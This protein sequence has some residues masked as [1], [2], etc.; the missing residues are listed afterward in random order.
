MTAETLTTIAGADATDAN[1]AGADA[2][3]DADAGTAGSSAVRGELVRV[4]FGD[5]HRA[6]HGPWR[7]LL[8]T[9]PF[10]RRS[11]LAPDAQLRLAYGRLRTL[12]S[13]LDSAFRLAAD[14]VALANMHEWLSPVDTTL[15]TVA[16][17]HYNLFL[18]SL[19]DHDGDVRRDLSAFADLTRIGT[20]LCTELDHGN[21]ATALETTAD[22]DRAR[23]GFL[24]RT[25][26][27]G[28]QKFMPNT[29]AAGGPKSGVVAARLLV[30]GRDL[31][32][33]LFLTA[34]T[35]A[36]GPLPGVR[37]RL[38]PRRMGS[39]VD[40][41]LTSFDGVFVP[42]EALLSGAQGRLD[43]EGAFTSEVVNRRS[44]FLLSIGRV[45][46]GKLS[47]SASAVGSVRAALAVAVR[48]GS[49]RLIGGVRASERV[50]VMA[51]RSHYAPLAGALATAYAMT[52]LHR[53][54]LRAWTE[55]DRTER[56]RTGVAGRVEAERLVAVAKAWI[57][58]EARVVIT[59]CR[60]RCGAQGLLEN[61]GLAALV[62]GIEGAIT[63]EGDNIAIHAKAAA[64]MVSG[65]RP[66]RPP[67]DP[68]GRE[69]TDPVFLRELLAA[70]ECVELDRARAG[71][72]AAAPG[73][74]LGRW[75]AGASAALRAATAHAQ[76][77]AAEAVAAAADALPP[78]AAAGE[79]LHTL[80]RLF[81]LE[82]IAP[83]GGDLLN[84]GFMAGRHISELPA[85]T[86]RLAARIA[87]QAQMLTGA[88]DLPDEWL[89]D[90]PVTDAGYASAY[91]DPEG[92][93]H[94]S[95]VEARR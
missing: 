65:H 45:T 74:A 33:F 21:D 42:R 9:E 16:G 87:G 66:P 49:H 19:L 69:L 62:T 61:N 36:E 25:P 80:G 58:W 56:D 84:E 18:G 76:L 57:T 26:H 47:M 93:W 50:P 77:R 22:Y 10:R 86:D 64:G 29:S 85:E 48:H 51:H 68:A 43:A 37:V 8:T 52:L 34:L 3:A 17:I 92:P 94:R 54:V 5:D 71:M 90:V 6:A 81:A 75:N 91:D 63:A 15:T 67:A 72:R 32:V 95:A 14:P 46:A 40:H 44:R 59:Q 20:F 23:D 13:T 60:E 1:A 39:A 41:C 27:A 28:A 82:R 11:D 88:F 30:D 89:A 53:T 79:V 78:G 2:D 35:G 31:G 70:V 24:L 4:L 55:Y 12:N 83:H 7:T 73:D 38:L